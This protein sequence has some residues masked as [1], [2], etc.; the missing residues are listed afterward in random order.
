MSSGFHL[1]R[2]LLAYLLY[3]AEQGGE[4]RRGGPNT[5]LR[6]FLTESIPGSEQ[7]SAS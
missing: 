7:T 5:W 3:P 6:P 2:N 4:G 1:T